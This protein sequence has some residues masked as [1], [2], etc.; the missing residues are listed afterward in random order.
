[1]EELEKSWKTKKLPFRKQQPFIEDWALYEQGKSVWCFY[2]MNIM[3]WEQN[4]DIRGHTVPEDVES[5]AYPVWRDFVTLFL[6]YKEFYG[7]LLTPFTRSSPSQFTFNVHF[8][9]FF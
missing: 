7:S 8:H 1:M 3:Y 2:K 5:L 6:A 9:I 4:Q